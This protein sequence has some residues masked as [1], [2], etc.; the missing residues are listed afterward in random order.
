MKLFKSYLEQVDDQTKYGFDLA[1]RYAKLAAEYDKD[2][3]TFLQE[4]LDHWDETL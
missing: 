1:L 2:I 4:K 3:I